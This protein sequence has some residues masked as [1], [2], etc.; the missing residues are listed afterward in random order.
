M[1]LLGDTVL[2]TP[3]LT[4]PHPRLHQRAFVLQPLLELAPDL[5]APGLGRLEHHL[6]ATAGQRVQRLGP[7]ESPPTMSV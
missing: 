2:Q 1:L 7:L 6:P 4:V 5:L 3:R